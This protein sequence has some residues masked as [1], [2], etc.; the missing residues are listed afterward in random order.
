[1]AGAMHASLLHKCMAASLPCWLGFRTT[2]VTEAD[3]GPCLMQVSV[4]TLGMFAKRLGRGGNTSY[5]EAL[6]VRHLQ[7]QPGPA[8]G[9]SFCW[10]P[11]G[12]TRGTQSSL[13]IFV[14]ASHRQLRRLD[15]VSQRFGKATHLAALL[16]LSCQRNPLCS[17]QG[18]ALQAACQ[19]LYLQRLQVTIRQSTESLRLMLKVHCRGPSLAGHPGQ[20]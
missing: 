13:V 12:A 11:P 17:I 15:V 8:E 6:K 5:E 4:S 10:H 19:I 20:T 1:M 3:I 7:P 2:H 18:L 9:L 16:A 14:R